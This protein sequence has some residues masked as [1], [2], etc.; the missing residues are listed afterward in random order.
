MKQVKIYGDLLIEKEDFKEAVHVY[1]EAIKYNPE[2]SDLY[3]NLGISYSRINEFSLAK[4]CF[5]K[6]VEINSDLYNA[7]YRLGQ[8]A[9]LYRDIENAERY[10]SQSIEGETEGKSYYQLAKI[11]LIKNNKNKAVLYINRAIEFDIKFYNMIEE[12]PIFLPIKQLIKKPNNT[13]KKQINES[14][15]EKIISDY[16]DNTY[17][18]TKILNEKTNNKGIKRKF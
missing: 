11:Y 15:K 6:A 1:T 4:D 3:Y 12:E 16:L 10:F 7:Y 17:N 9:L 2:N 5:E 13:E 14:E 18:L 8:I